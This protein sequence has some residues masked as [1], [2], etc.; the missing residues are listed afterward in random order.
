MN[1]QQNP[2][3]KKQ[4]VILPICLTLHSVL[5]KKGFIKKPMTLK[6]DETVKSP[7]SVM[8]D[9]IRHPEASEITGF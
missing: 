5:H 1:L 6:S 8:P 4:I 3:G 9:R 7:I 2:A